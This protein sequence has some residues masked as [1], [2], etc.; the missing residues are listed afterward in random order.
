MSLLEKIIALD[1]S[2]F[3]ALNGM[4]APWADTLMVGLSEMLVWIP[5]YV[6]LLYL[7]QRH[8]GWKGLAWAVPVIALMILC[9]DKGSVVLFKETFQ[10]LRPCHEPVL[11]GLVHTVNEHC[12]GRFGF[13]SSHASNHFAI[14]AF[15]GLL[16]RGTYRYAMVSL[17]LW[18]ALVAYSRI[19]LG[20]HYPG[21]VL[22]GGLFGVTV[23]IISFG[24]FRRITRLVPATQGS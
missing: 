22:I 11:Q 5:L 2:A 19:Y 14:A 12:G 8:Y 3:L 16:L 6:F 13:V 10:R 9:S 24:I 18:A 15:M 20:V 21:D 7:L 17:L 4:H 23:G 1:R